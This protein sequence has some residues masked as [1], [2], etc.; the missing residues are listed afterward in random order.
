MIGVVLYEGPSRFDPSREIAA[1][2]T[3]SSN[4]KKT[5]GIPQVWMIDKAVSPNAALKTG[6]DQALCGDCRLR[7][8]GCY[9]ITYQAPRSVREA[10]LRGAYLSGEKAD[11]W[12][13]SRARTYGWRAIRI[14]AY[15]DPYSV[16]I[17]VWET[18]Q[19]RLKD[20]KILGYTQQWRKDD[21]QPY[22]KFCMASVFSESEAQDALD[23]GW[24]YFRVRNSV[25]ESVLKNEIV[26]PA[27]KEQDYRMNCNVCRVCNG[28]K[29]KNSG[30]GT[31]DKDSRASV[32]IVAHGIKAKTAKFAKIIR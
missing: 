22:A 11:K 7:S 5:G 21:A 16:P 27:S 30:G 6:E 18:L 9:V 26:C 32:V 19:S 31:L 17:E 13:T 8:N 2:M 3:V 12:W 24:R 1:I 15:G 28:V 14:G 25:D 23:L 4:N 29:T 10:Y 20:A